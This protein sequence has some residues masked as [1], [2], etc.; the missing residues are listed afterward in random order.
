MNWDIEAFWYRSLQTLIS[1][2]N[3]RGHQ[4]QSY[5]TSISII[6]VNFGIRY[7]SRSCWVA[8]LFAW[9]FMFLC[10]RVS[11]P[12]A[13]DSR[14]LFLR[15][16]TAA[17][18]APQ[19]I[20][21][22][23][24]SH[25]ATSTCWFQTAC[26]LSHCPVLNLLQLPLRSYPGSSE[27]LYWLCC[28]SGRIE[29]DWIRHGTWQAALSYSIGKPFFCKQLSGVRLIG[30]KVLKKTSETFFLVWGLITRETGTT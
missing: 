18:L 10:H 4:Y 26:S 3:I 24:S 15:I 12:R 29:I 17:Q 5:Q 23:R 20:D 8:A 11:A 22:E 21:E 1:R 16:S 13:L 9:V 28:H 6:M 25:S 14:T 27:E 7:P 30:S 19:R 2:F